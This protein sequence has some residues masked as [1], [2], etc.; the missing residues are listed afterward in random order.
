MPVLGFVLLRPSCDLANPPQLMLHRTMVAS[1]AMDG[2]R[3]TRRG[4]VTRL[5]N[6]MTAQPLPVLPM[7]AVVTFSWIAE[8][9]P[10]VTG[11]MLD[12][13]GWAVGG[14]GMPE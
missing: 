1:P 4:R 3:V 14:W 11:K 13:L 12:A 7:A 5:E 2:T 10:A 8:P 6:D 9:M